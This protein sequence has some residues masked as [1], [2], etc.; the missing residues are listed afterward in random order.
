MLQSLYPVIRETITAPAFGFA[1]SDPVESYLRVLGDDVEKLTMSKMQ[2]LLL[3]DAIQRTFMTTIMPAAETAVRA[4]VAVSLLSCA[5]LCCVCTRF[6]CVNA[7]VFVSEQGLRRIPLRELSDIV[8]LASGA[9]GS[10]SKAKYRGADVAIKKTKCVCMCCCISTLV[11]LDWFLLRTPRVASRDAAAL[12]GEIDL[13]G[14]LG[15]HPH[16]V[17]VYGVCDEDRDNLC[18]VMELCSYGSVQAFLAAQRSAEPVSVAAPS[19]CRD[20]IPQHVVAID[21]CVCVLWLLLDASLGACAGHILPISI[22]I[23]AFAPPQRDAPRYPCCE[24]V[25]I[26]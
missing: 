21:V 15:P 8:E 25:S 9:F 11:V 18:L 6:L 10:V 17:S 26:E 16:I 3:R 1:L 20:C 4:C 19:R 12:L 2:R 24:S 22:W 14:K 23:D 13:L 5:L 7:C